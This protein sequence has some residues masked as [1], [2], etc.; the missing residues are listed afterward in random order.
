MV[1]WDI[2][3]N[4]AGDMSDGNF[5]IQEGPPDPTPPSVTV[6]QPTE[7]RRWPPAAPTP[8]RGHHRTTSV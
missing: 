2:A 5:T 6:T 4:Q 7:A 1:A 3:G 8:S